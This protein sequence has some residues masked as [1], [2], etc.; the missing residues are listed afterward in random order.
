MVRT[1]K[2]MNW[3]TMQGRCCLCAF[4]HQEGHCCELEVT[5]E[6]RKCP[7]TIIEEFHKFYLHNFLSESNSSSSFSNPTIFNWICSLMFLLADNHHVATRRIHNL[8]VK[9]INQLA[10][11]WLGFIHQLSHISHES[12]FQ[13]HLE[14]E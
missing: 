12:V 11:P 8:F 5:E 7:G 14:N 4:C 6:S 9:L 1:G 2:K 10:K 13:L 3:S